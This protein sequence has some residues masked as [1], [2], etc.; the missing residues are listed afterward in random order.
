MRAVLR[1]GSGVAAV[2]VYPRPIAMRSA[3]GMRHFVLSRVCRALRCARIPASPARRAEL[4]AGL[5]GE[6]KKGA[7]LCHAASLFATLAF[8]G[9]RCLMLF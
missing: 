6:K 3:R 8:R 5:R 2:G 1:V 9:A 7:C 4:V